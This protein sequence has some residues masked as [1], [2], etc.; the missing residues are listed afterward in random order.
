MKK[1]LIQ[2][3]AEAS[4]GNLLER[5]RLLAAWNNA[6]GN[7]RADD[8]DESVMSSPQNALA[9]RLQTVLAQRAL[10]FGKLRVARPARTVQ[11][12]Q[13]T[14]QLPVGVVGDHRTSRH[15][16]QCGDGVGRFACLYIHCTVLRMLVNSRH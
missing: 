11:T 3:T 7:L 8:K 5:A 13:G 10:E 12:T 14:V 1:R 9:A 2:E 15:R 4:A 16:L 6:L